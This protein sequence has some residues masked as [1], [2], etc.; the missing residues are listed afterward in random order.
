MSQVRTWVFGIV[1]L[2]LGSVGGGSLAAERVKPESLLP[3]DAPVVVKV[4]SLAELERALPETALG[5]I[6]AEEDVRDYFAPVRAWIE[7]ASAA[8]EAALKEEGVDLAVQTARATLA[9]LRGEIVLAIPR[10]VPVKRK[11]WRGERTAYVP[12]ILVLAE[13]EDPAAFGRVVKGLRRLAGGAGLGGGGLR[14]NEA[15]AVAACKT[16]GAAQTLYHRTDWD[17]DAVLEYALAFPVLHAQV[18]AAGNPIK[19]ISE[20][21]A[22]AVTPATARHGYWFNDITA[23]GEDGPYV[24]G[25]NQPDDYGIC[26]NPARYPR[27][28][29]HT[30]IMDTTGTVW[31]RD[32]G[33]A[34]PVLVFPADPRA[35]GWVV[36]GNRKPPRAAPAEADGKK[37]GG[38]EV[39]TLPLEEGYRAWVF[40]AGSL[41]VVGISPE[42]PEK[43]IAAINA[44][45]LEEDIRDNAIYA[46]LVTAEEPRALV[47][48]VHVNVPVLKA[49]IA[50]NVPEREAEDLRSFERVWKALGLTGLKAVT[51]RTRTDPPGFVSESAFVVEGAPKGLLALAGEAPVSEEALRLVPA[52][53]NMFMAARVRPDRVMPLVRAVARAGDEKK[54]AVE[55]E[56]GLVDLKEKGLDL[57]AGLLGALGDEVVLIVLPPGAAAQNPFMGQIAGVVLAWR[58]KEGAALGVFREAIEKMIREAL[59]EERGA[60]KFERFEYKGAAITYLKAEGGAPMVMVTAFAQLSPAW[61]V[62]DGWLYLGLSVQGVKRM[63]RGGGARLVEAEEFKTALARSGGKLGAAVAYT[64]T[65]ARVEGAFGMIGMAAGLMRMGLAFDRRRGPEPGAEP[66]AAD[67]FSVERLKKLVMDMLDPAHLPPPDV[68]TQHLYP[69]VSVMRVGK[70]GWITRGHSPLGPVSGGASTPQVGMATGGVLAAM[71]LPAMSRSRANARRM[72]C[73]SNLRQMGLGIKMFAQDNDERFPK[74]LGELYPE[75]IDHAKIFSCP[76]N[77]SN[78]QAIKEGQPIAADQ[79]SYVYVSGLSDVMKSANIL[80]FDRPGNHG[81]DGVNVIFLDTHVE[82]MRTDKFMET[83]VKQL[84]AHRAAGRDVKLIPADAVELPDLGPLGK[85]PAKEELEPVDV[86]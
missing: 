69:E 24:V 70:G 35:A 34:A 14:A 67:P 51:M 48:A 76:Q 66:E 38:V 75:Y 33:A 5:K 22:L 30:F 3:P 23:D 1:L 7:E 10:F 20:P 58:V 29:R 81:G 39:L 4:G 56:K 64:D 26:A 55:L 85:P 61:A 72:H 79:T 73:A 11:G 63:L 50:K 47:N 21:V 59:A 82:W 68:V 86:F 43:L 15:N 12:E 25:G 37:T 65:P 53:S 36:A 31:A 80:A 41:A 83:L 18:D 17:N 40:T 52:G 6:L 9:S 13:I 84:K 8:G 19:L 42:G 44:G 27:S 62:K 2:A 60:P 74:E 54:G 49:A 46:E 45:G 57:E 77:P 32:Q 16:I 28:G 71:L 78:W